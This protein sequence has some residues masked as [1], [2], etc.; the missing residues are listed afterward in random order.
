[1][2]KGF[3]HTVSSTSIAKEC[4][5]L[6][7]SPQDHIV[8]AFFWNGT[9]PNRVDEVRI[10]ELST[11]RHHNIKTCQNSSSSSVQSSPVTD[12]PALKAELCFEET[13]ERFAVVAAI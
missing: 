4:I 11:T 9:I 6:L 13:I 10:P 1:M 8:D 3:Y 7:D 5:G 2:K 12:H